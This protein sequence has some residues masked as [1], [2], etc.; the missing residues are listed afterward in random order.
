MLP[1]DMSFAT[2]N[3]EVS[4]QVF[5][6]VSAS[7]KDEYVLRALDAMFYFTADNM[8]GQLPVKPLSDLYLRLIVI[9]NIDIEPEV[10]I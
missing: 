6:H 4:T 1:Y 3:F 10:V 5:N 9:L 2:K 7:R 8:Y